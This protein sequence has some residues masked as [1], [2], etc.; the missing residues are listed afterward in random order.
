[1]RFVAAGVLRPIWPVQTSIDATTQNMAAATA[2]A[3]NAA[4]NSVHRRPNIDSLS[5]G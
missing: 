2:V 3:D 1:M 4:I 5:E